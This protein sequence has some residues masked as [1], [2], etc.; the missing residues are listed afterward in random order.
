MTISQETDEVTAALNANAGDTPPTTWVVMQFG[1]GVRPQVAASGQLP[2]ALAHF[3]QLAFMIVALDRTAEYQVAG[4]D[5]DAALQGLSLYSAGNLQLTLQPAAGL[6]VHPSQ[7]ELPTLPAESFETTAS[8][9]LVAL[10]KRKGLGNDVAERFQNSSVAA[11]WVRDIDDLI[12]GD[13]PTADD[14]KGH[15]DKGDVDWMWNWLRRART[16]LSYTATVR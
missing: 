14:V 6:T 16:M 1:V 4:N 7:P 13:A 12:L 15:F 10:S 9:L 2:L 5:D 3:Y 11:S 8:L